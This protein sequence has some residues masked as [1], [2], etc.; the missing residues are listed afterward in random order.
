VVQDSSAQA[1][2]MVEELFFYLLE[3]SMCN[4]C[5]IYRQ[6]HPDKKVDATKFRLAAAD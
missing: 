6:L 2:Q 1:G 3:V 4:A 5:T